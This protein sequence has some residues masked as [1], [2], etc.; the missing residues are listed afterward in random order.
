MFG[1]MWGLVGSDFFSTHAEMPRV[2]VKLSIELV[3]VWTDV[4][5]K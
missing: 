1:R 4:G 5:L 2:E 3:D